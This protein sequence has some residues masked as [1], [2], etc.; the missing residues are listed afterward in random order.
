MESQLLSGS[1]DKHTMPHQ[2]LHRLPELEHIPKSPSPPQNVFIEQIDEFLISV[3][4]LG[5]LYSA[6]QGGVR[7]KLQTM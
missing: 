1:L 6:G 2:T 5:K 7:R 3:A 4:G